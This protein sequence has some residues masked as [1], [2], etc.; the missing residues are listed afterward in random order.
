[1]NIF[2]WGDGNYQVPQSGA[3]PLDDFLMNYY[4]YVAAMP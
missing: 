1:M 2:T 3:L 4:G